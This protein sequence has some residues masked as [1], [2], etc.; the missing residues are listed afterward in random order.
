MLVRK[1]FD[2][3]ANFFHVLRDQ[4]VEFG[5]EVWEKVCSNAHAPRGIELCKTFCR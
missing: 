2:W 3:L 4:G 5:Q 1:Y